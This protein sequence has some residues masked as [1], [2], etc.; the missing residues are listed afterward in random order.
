MREATWQPDWPVDAARTL[1]PLRHG[2]ADPS[3]RRDPAGVWWRTT[4]TPEG[5]S[6]VAL[7]IDGQGIHHAAWGPGSDWVLGTVPGWLGA[8]DDRSDF[9][10]T[11]PIV[12]RLDHRF[13]GLRLGRTNRIWDTLVAAIIEQK[14][15]SVEAHQAWRSLLLTAGTPA[16]GPA[17]ERMRVPPTPEALLELTDWQWHR[18]GLDGQRRR[19]L[20]AAATVAQR[21]EAGV[22]MPGQDALR[23]L[24][25]VPGIGI[26]TAAETMQ[27]A[28]GD[29]DAVSVGDY[30]VPSLVGWALI[31][32]RVDDERMLELLEPFR[33]HRQRVVRLIECGAPRPPR[34]GPR[35][36][37]RDYRST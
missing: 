6:T 36:P 23:R 9:R 27:R 13:A 21:L 10:P 2:G 11:D 33:P 25:V 1:G 8:Q 31:G 4:T 16:P 14:V 19:T 22:S 37:V 12:L 34:R 24:Q 29:P 17:G 7:R 5:P 3:F 35:A 30:H 18:C 28:I 15:T 20:R 26:W 32:E